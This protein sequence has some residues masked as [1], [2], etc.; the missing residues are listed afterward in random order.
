MKTVRQKGT[1]EKTK[2]E[3]VPVITLED[4]RLLAPLFGEGERHIMMIEEKLNIRISTKGNRLA[5]RGSPQKT[6][7][8]EHIIR[9]LYK[10]LQQ[11]EQL[12]MQ[13]IDEAIMEH[14]N[15]ASIRGKKSS[16]YLQT[17]KRR[18][19]ARSPQ[20]EAYIQALYQK[21][22]V[23]GIG[24]AGTGK[25]YL[26]V[27]AGAMML[28]EGKLERIILS[29]PAVEAG[30][31]LGFLPGDMREKIDPYLRPLYDALYDMMPG[32]EVNRYMEAGA[33]E[34]APLAFMR[35]RTL[36]NAFIILD[37]AQNATPTQMKMFL[38]RMGEN[39]HMVVTGDPSQIDLPLGAKS[40]LADAMEVLPNI[41]DAE[42]ICFDE[43]DVV[44]HDMV[45]RII[46]A[47]NAREVLSEK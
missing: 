14:S 42:T 8:G 34:I 13:D 26:A 23:F 21:Q 37:E 45:T 9:H 4:N 41:E 36:A 3:H 17:P 6:N 24:P 5:L 33:I 12:S 22:L 10:K 16:I 27:A 47:Y 1:L 39:S 2:A 31:S 15:E 25:T 19:H 43:R 44:R 38:T 46:K 32:H 35:G 40:G 29:R 30:E 18:I 11:G 28:Q 20:Q 7:A